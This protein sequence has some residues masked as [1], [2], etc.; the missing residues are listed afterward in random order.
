MMRFVHHAQIPTG[1]QRLFPPFRFIPEKINAAQ[2]QLLPL[3]RIAGFVLAIPLV[4]KQTKAKI[5]TAAHFHQPL[6]Q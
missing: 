2:H 1:F 6:M 4:I 3:E 5:E